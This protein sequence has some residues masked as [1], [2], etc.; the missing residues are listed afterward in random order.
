VNDTLKGQDRFMLVLAG[1]VTPKL[2]YSRLAQEPCR[3]S[4][5]WSR[6]WI[7][8]GD[9]RC[10]PKDHPESHFRMAHETLLQYVPV[11]PEHVFRIRGEDPPPSA[12]RD[13]EKGLRD[14]FQGQKWPRFDLV[15]L[16]LGPDGHTASL[17]AGTPAM[18]HGDRW[19]VGNVVRARQTVRITMTVPVLNQAGHAWFLVTGAKKSAAFVQAQ[20]EPDEGCPASL[21]RPNPGDLRWYVDRAVVSQNPSAVARERGK[22]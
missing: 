6:L 14:I 2:F 19:V 18:M 16:G 9:E 17:M 20:Q 8:W 11:A 15:L 10:V 7:F 12:A 5:P 4:I 1:G 3:A 13:Y 21:I 22:D